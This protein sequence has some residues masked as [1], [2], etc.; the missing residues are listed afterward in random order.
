MIG[1]IADDLTGA[2][3]IGAIGWRHGLSAEVVIEGQVNTD[4][5][6][7]C[8][9]TD[10][11]SCPADEA[12][13]RAAIA[14]NQLQT[15]GVEWIYKKVDSVLRGWVVAELEAVMEGVETLR[16][17]LVP[18]N[19]SLGRVI[20]N[21][22]YFVDGK[23]LHETD[24]RFDPEHPRCSSEV[25]ELLGVSGLVQIYVCT[26][27]EPLPAKGIIVGEARTPKD[28]HRWASSREQC[29]LVA[30]GAEFFDALLQAESA[31]I[32]ASRYTTETDKLGKPELQMGRELFVCGSLSQSTQD[33][34]SGLK[35]RGV[36]VFS[37]P[38]DVARG[39]EI[40][41]SW[42]ETLAR[43][44]SE[45]LV[46]NLRVALEIGL[47]RIRDGQVARLLPEYLAQLAE[48]VI[49]RTNVAQ[50][51][52]EGGATAASLI[53]RL[54]WSRLK[55]F[56]ENAPGVVT[57]QTS[58]TPPRLLTIKPGSYAWPEDINTK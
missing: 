28:V 27:D 17:L 32:V 35:E 9:D 1:V 11:R 21:G 58:E 47:P 7:V 26:L 50:I 22:K 48:A 41:A 36:P 20:R 31:R 24:F 34:L 12:G 38:A 5:D 15:H 53:R 55:V 52:A 57:L 6:L 4:A 49:L 23:A 40:G 33:F 30:G 29:G 44:I 14:A 18:T 8:V 25:R 16:T 42:H 46:S 51:Y 43:Q 3:E 54:G 56:Q 37:L 39:T 2:A 13:R 19:P 45:A 10:S